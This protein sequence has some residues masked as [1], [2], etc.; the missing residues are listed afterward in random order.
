MLQPRI[1]VSNASPL[2]FQSDIFPAIVSRLSV[3]DGNLTV[4]VGTKKSPRT[5]SERIRELYQQ[6]LENL[7]VRDQSFPVKISR[8]LSS[9]LATPGYNPVSTTRDSQK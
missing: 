2:L 9:S 5:C 6:T 8:Y 4:D 1:S 3:N 7:T